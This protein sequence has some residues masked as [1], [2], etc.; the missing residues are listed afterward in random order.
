MAHGGHWNMTL[1]KYESRNGKKTS[2]DFFKGVFWE[3]EQ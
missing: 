2:I 3:G 1:S